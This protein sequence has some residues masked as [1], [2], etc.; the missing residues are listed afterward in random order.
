MRFTRPLDDASEVRDADSGIARLALADAATKHHRLLRHIDARHAVTLHRLALSPQRHEQERFV[1]VSSKPPHDERRAALLKRAVDLAG[2]IRRFAAARNVPQT[3]IWR[4]LQ[5][6]RI[7]PRIALVLADPA[8][9]K[10]KSHRPTP[11]APAPTRTDGDDL[12]S[13]RIAKGLMVSDLASLMG[14]QPQTLR[15]WEQTTIP[16]DE[17]SRIRLRLKRLPPALFFLPSELTR[18]RQTHAVSLHQAAL[19]L[20]FSKTALFR[21]E[22]GTEPI[23]QY[24]LERAE[25]VF[26][27][28]KEPS[29]A[30][31]RLARFL[32]AYGITTTQAEALLGIRRGEVK[33]LLATQRELPLHDK[34]RATIKHH[35]G[36][37]APPTVISAQTFIDERSR[38]GLTT[39]QAATLLAIAPS[40]LATIER[41][42]A[43]QPL[44]A[45]LVLHDGNQ[46]ATR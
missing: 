18:A 14:I 4:A 23:S 15:S 45:R 12:A 29:H 30:G 41:T 3:S 43:Y 8:V 36:V 22:H 7:P 9:E 39:T 40:R 11:K 38:R 27:H 34:I 5:T 2:G 10:R 20:E 21:L 44:L 17:L 19:A 26:P 28:I 33:R 32:D 42:H 16:T 31:E 6:G 35:T 24:L 46:T 37:D 25:R 13:L 1:A